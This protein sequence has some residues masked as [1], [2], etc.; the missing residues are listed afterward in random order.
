MITRLS[1]IFLMFFALSAPTV[2]ANAAAGVLSTPATV[3]AGS[4]VTITASDALS[5]STTDMS[6]N[7]AANGGFGN[8][9]CTAK[10]VGSYTTT[11]QH[12][13]GVCYG[14][15]SLVGW[16][17]SSATSFT[18]TSGAQVLTVSVGAITPPP[19]APTPVITVSTVGNVTTVTNSGNADAVN[20]SVTVYNKTATIFNA[21]AFTSCTYTYAGKGGRKTRSGFRCDGGFIPAGTST[22]ITAS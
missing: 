21:P 3:Q 15:G 20:Q 22:T 5:Y 1:L 8:V 19:P 12:V 14:P 9:N 17:G 11:P 7:P 4:Y 10:V 13:E 18:V 6:W 2:A 16:V